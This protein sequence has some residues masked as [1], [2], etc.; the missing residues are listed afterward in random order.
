MNLSELINE[1]VKLKQQRAALATADSEL[2][3]VL[4]KLEADIMHTMNEAGLS[5]AASDIGHSVTMA[6]KAHPTITDW[7]QFYAYV[8]ST[9][10][11]DLLHKRLSSTAFRDRWD[12][13]EI[14][15]G[16]V[17]ADVWGVSVTTSRK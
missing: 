15:P 7:D 5:K 9:N 11:F 13:G 17:T 12:A 2:S 4:A 3:K 10:S 8:T 16:A 1:L 6:K 14:I